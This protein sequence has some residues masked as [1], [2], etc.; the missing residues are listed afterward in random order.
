MVSMVDNY[1]H[2][3]SLHKKYP[4]LAVH[5]YTEVENLRIALDN[6]RVTVALRAAKEVHEQEVLAK[7]VEPQVSVESNPPEEPATVEPPTYEEA[8]APELTDLVMPEL[9]PPMDP[10]V[11]TEPAIP[12]LLERSHSITPEPAAIPEPAPAVL[13]EQLPINTQV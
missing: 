4:D 7:F 12:H 13:S 5:V 10:Y 2:F 9:S 11:S 1:T 8:T 6:F 3:E